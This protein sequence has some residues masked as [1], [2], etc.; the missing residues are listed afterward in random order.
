M[1]EKKKGKGKR[2]EVRDPFCSEGGKKGEGNP[3]I[4]SIGKYLRE[5]CL[6]FY[7]RKREKKGWI[8]RL[9]LYTKR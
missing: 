3:L 9:F 5:K 8:M 1:G 4:S 6:I 2:Y 7:K